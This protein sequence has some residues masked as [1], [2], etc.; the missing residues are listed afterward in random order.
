MG[1]GCKRLCGALLVVSLGW[2][3]GGPGCRIPDAP[4][5]V[6]R[7]PVL[8]AP[9]DRLLILAPHPDDEVL[10][11]GGI[12]QR[13]LALRLPV[14]VVFFTY[15]DNNEWSFL[16]YRKHPVLRPSAVRR[17]G[18]V[19]HDEALQAAKVLG[20][21]EDQLTF[22]GYP[23]FGTMPIWK[24]HW[25]ERPPFQSML[26]RVDA[27]P[28]ADALRPGAPY[29][30]EEI[31]RD[32][33]TVLA[34]FRPTKVFVSSPADHMPDH[35]A[36]YLFTRVALW[37]LASEMTS[38]VYPYLVHFKRWPRPGGYSLTTPLDPPKTFQTSVAWAEYVLAPEELDRKR[39]AIAA[40]RT[41]YRSSR[42]YL[43]S[44]IRP[45]ELFGDFPSVALRSAPT[46]RLLSADG[47]G[48]AEEPPDE[49]TDQERAA[50]VGLEERSAALAGDTLVLSIAFS[51]PLAKAVEAS[52]FVFGYR[53]DRPFAQM[54]KLHIRL[55]A[56]THAIYDQDRELPRSSCEVHRHLRRITLRIPLPL[57]GE[58]QRI[59]TSART[60]LGEVP[61]DVASWRILELEDHGQR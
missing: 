6:P 33:T 61:L 55:G 48:P 19:R 41:Q 25:G 24:A 15:G 34:D 35:S 17:M 14:R 11:C 13:A 16:L 2:L 38:P 51:R 8:L 30:G 20:L 23:D 1:N 3:V 37:D 29:K 60:S 52:V 22:L 7:T 45:N 4:H 40:H 9:E 58:P 46:P 43:Q 50:F 36:L 28:Y 26:T 59:L 32:L 47:G 31:V 5:P 27:V 21:S 54:P 44:F 57:L 10:G 18:E 12:I 53:S 56:L 49:L 42:R 39:Q